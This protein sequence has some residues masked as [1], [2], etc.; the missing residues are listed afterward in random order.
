MRMGHAHSRVPV[1]VWTHVCGHFVS[2]AQAKRCARRQKALRKALRHKLQVLVMP[3][4]W[5][6]GAIF[7]ALRRR[8][9]ADGEIPELV[10]AVH[11]EHD[12]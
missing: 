11:D 1:H 2:H 4:V 3:M 8:T 10:M 7:V 12:N 6:S 5:K 9:D